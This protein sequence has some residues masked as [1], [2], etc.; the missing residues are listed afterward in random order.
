[1]AVEPHAN[2]TAGAFCGA[3]N[4]ATKRAAGVLAACERSRCG[5]GG[6]PDGPAERGIATGATARRN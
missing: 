4:G 6:A 5:W 2:A 1:M 3:P